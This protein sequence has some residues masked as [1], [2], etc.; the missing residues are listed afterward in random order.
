MSEE[1]VSNTIIEG[2]DSQP[3][4]ATRSLMVDTPEQTKSN[5]R[6]LLD[7]VKQETATL[8]AAIE[9]NKKIM[10][11]MEEFRAEEILKGR[12]DAGQVVKQ[13]IETPAEYA[14]RILRGEK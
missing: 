1:E 3:T 2:R 7:Q 10:A 8:K 9:E 6:T 11:K 4:P 13:V 5:T 14:K 12:S